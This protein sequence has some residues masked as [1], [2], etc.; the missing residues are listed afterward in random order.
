MIPMSLG[1]IVLETGGRLL[2][3]DSSMEI[4]SV[5]TD[6]RT[7]RGGELFLALRGARYDAHD[8][9]EQALEK[10][11]RALVVSRVDGGLLE[12]A[13]SLRVGV[14][15]VGNTLTALLR[16]GAAQRRRGHYRVAGITGSSG[17]TLTKDFLFSIMR[18]AGSAVAPPGSY[19]NEVGVPLTLLEADVDT[20][21][22]IL[23]MGARG[24]GHV[25]R[26][27]RYARPE[28]G[29]I[30]NIGWAHLRYFGS[31]EGIAEAKSELVASLPPDGLAILP[32]EDDFRKYMESKSSAP[33]VHFGLSP[34]ARVRAVDLSADERGRHSFVLSVAGEELARITLPLPGMH[35][36]LSAL[37]ACAAALHWGVGVADIVEGLENA[38]VSKGRMEMIET[39]SGVTVINDA[40]NANPAS[41]RSAL[42]TF[43]A[44][45]GKRRA[46]AVLGDMAELGRYSEE[47]HREVGRLAVECGTDVLIAVGRRARLMARAAMEAGL[48]RGSVF[49]V[50][51]AEQ[52]AEI[53]RAILEP[54]DVVLVKGS[55]FLGLHRLPAMVA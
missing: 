15:Q 55:N 17:K 33:V 10:G 41:M 34:G 26:L 46:I 7:M 31:R 51:T 28:V 39:R 24:K 16:L 52:A 23:E 40:Y 50:R 2:S 13:R 38:E 48:P 44:L 45:A 5:S 25:E 32:W 21:Y 42:E 54:G 20:D 35:I 49:T 19:N 53:L 30:T 1:E 9:L 27:C 43:A 22:L 18:R 8:F 47:A 36:V 37:A 29:V 6:T 3:G 12:R 4:S 14:V 11:A